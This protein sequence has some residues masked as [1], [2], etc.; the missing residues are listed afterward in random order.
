VLWI[1]AGLVQLV[2]S[3]IHQMLLCVVHVVQKE[4]A[5]QVMEKPLNR[6]PQPAPVKQ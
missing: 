1:L 2:L 6:H 4:T 5:V 3:S